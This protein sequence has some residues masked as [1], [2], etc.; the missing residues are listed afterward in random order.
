MKRPQFGG[1]LCGA[2]LIAA[3]VFGAGCFTQKPSEAP[4]QPTTTATTTS[5]TTSTVALLDTTGWKAYNDE[6]TGMSFKY[7]ADWSQDPSKPEP[8]SE[9]FWLDGNLGYV[10]FSKYPQIA[11]YIFLEVYAK[12]SELS[13][14][15]IERTTGFDT[16]KDSIQRTVLN[17]LP[18]VR[19]YSDI[20]LAPEHLTASGQKIGDRFSFM[21]QI[22]VQ[23][24]SMYYYFV[25]Q[26][27]S[28][29][30]TEAE[31]RRGE[32]QTLLS[33]FKSFEPTK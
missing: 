8:L 24:K 29:T 32:W 2:I 7:P 25:V 13:S 4:P 28:L 15:E 33:T 9:P 18:A 10:R 19:E 5:E 30:K 27:A 17:E 16:N 21:E 22:I 31:K 3:A 14:Q 11:D 20:T 26:Q 6:K 1:I 23:K 12:K